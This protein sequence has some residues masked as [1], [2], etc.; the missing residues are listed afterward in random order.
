LQ[1]R[2]IARSFI[3]SVAFAVAFFI[4]SWETGLIEQ[5]G[6]SAARREITEPTA[7]ETVTKLALAFGE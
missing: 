2:A 6:A 7:S 5:Q 3:D 1:S 4:K